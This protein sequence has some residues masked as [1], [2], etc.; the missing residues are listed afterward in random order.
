MNKRVGLIHFKWKF[1]VILLIG[2][3]IYSHDAQAALRFWVSAGPGNWNNTANWSSFSG[4][5]GGASVPGAADV[6][7]FDASAGGNCTIDIVINVSGILLSN[8][9]GNILQNNFAVTIGANGYAQNSGTYTGDAAAFTIN[10]T[11]T[12]LLAGGTFISSSGNFT[13]SGSRASSQTLFTHSA[14]TFTHNN[15]TLIFNPAQSGCA[16]LTYTLDVIPATTFYNVLLNG[17][18]SCGIN[19]TFYIGWRCRK[20]NQ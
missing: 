12:F 19:A 3:S 15:G 16:A 11:G 14:G 18:A 20:C 1:L 8:Y 6:A 9:T 10:S 13:I 2:G 17:I 5:V 7:I 4:G